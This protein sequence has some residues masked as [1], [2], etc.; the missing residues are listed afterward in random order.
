D[1]G[2]VLCDRVQN[3]LLAASTQSVVEP[4]VVE[5]SVRNAAPV[6]HGA[7]EIEV[8][9][10]HFFVVLREGT[11]GGTA[12][13]LILQR[14]SRVGRTRGG[15]VI[16]CEQDWHE[17]VAADRGT[18]PPLRIPGGNPAFRERDSIL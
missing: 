8:S 11:R 5:R 9:V 16:E 2:V 14:L 13:Q 17:E 12:E 7:G 15:V 1:R 4:G 6:E 18:A 10:R 3:Q